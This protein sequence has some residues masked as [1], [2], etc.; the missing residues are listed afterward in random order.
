MVI[1]ENTKYM[2]TPRHQNV[3]QN[4][5]IVIHNLSFEYVEKFKYLWVTLTDTNDIREDIKRRINMG[6]EYYYTLEKILSSSLFSKKL[7]VAYETIILPDVFHDC[8]T[9]FLKLRQIECVR[10]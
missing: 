3:V 5:N 4:Q 6:N 10:E 1:S 2:I 8:E 7:K 9:R